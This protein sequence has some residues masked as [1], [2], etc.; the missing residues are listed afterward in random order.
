VTVATWN[1]RF[2]NVAQEERVAIQLPPPSVIKKRKKKKVLYRRRLSTT[3]LQA[4]SMLPSSSPSSA[5]VGTFK[6]GQA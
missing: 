5:S 3:S 2:G 4:P 6:A 1:G